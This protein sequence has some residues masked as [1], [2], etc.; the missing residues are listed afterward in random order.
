VYATG[1]VDTAATVRKSPRR[2]TAEPTIVERMF[3]SL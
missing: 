1:V 3:V 2:A